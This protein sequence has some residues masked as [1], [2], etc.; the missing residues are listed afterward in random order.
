MVHVIKRHAILSYCTFVMLWSFTWWGLI[1]TVI[2]IGTLFDP[3]INGAAISFMLLGG[4]GPS[5]MGLIMARVVGGKG[6]AWALL[7]HL[8]RWR[9]GWWWLAPFIP[10]ALNITIVSLYGQSGGQVSLV[11]SDRR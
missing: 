10:F 2:P 11:T 6:S 5:L 3:P 1:L 4:I 7:T 9:A 8:G